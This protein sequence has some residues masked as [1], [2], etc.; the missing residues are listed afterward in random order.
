LDY[1]EERYDQKT[2]HIE[3]LL[4]SVE[5]FSHVPNYLSF[6]QK[7]G[8]NN[9]MHPKE[10]KC[11]DDSSIIDL[12]EVTPSTGTVRFGQGAQNFQ[13]RGHPKRGNRVCLFMNYV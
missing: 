8:G 3:S 9:I 6:T 10:N 5:A 7:C 11:V 1:F 4:E 2:F 13:A 12:G